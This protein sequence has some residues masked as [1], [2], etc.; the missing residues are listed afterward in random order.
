M[1]KDSFLWPEIGR[2]Y[3]DPHRPST[4]ISHRD[5][6]RQPGS[7]DPLSI[8]ASSL[9]VIGAVTKTLTTITKFVRSVRDTRHV[10]GTERSAH[11]AEATSYKPTAWRFYSCCFRRS[12]YFRSIVG[13]GAQLQ[14]YRKR[15][16]QRL[17]RP[18]CKQVLS[19]G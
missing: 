3:G 16:Q 1:P 19:L 10:Q 6:N 5:N 11:G 15:E 4:D 9:A 17:E 12:H 14:E 7:V 13:H 8:T 2:N 18:K